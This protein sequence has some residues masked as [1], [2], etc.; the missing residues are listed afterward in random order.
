MLGDLASLKL[1]FADE[2]DKLNRI[3]G[4]FLIAIVLFAL[5]N[6]TMLIMA[7]LYASY[8][9]SCWQEAGLVFISVGVYV[10]VGIT[11]EI[12]ARIKFRSVSN[13]LENIRRTRGLS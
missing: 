1:Q 5:V 7:S 13:E 11:L 8:T 2:R 6:W 3:Q 4:P 10:A 9:L 12:I